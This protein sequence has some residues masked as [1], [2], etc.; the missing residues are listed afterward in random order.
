MAT[1]PNPAQKAQP[2]LCRHE[3]RAGRWGRFRLSCACA[4]NGGAGATTAEPSPPSY[5]HPPEVTLRSIWSEGAVLTDSP[6]SGAETV[7]TVPQSSL[8]HR[9]WRRIQRDSWNRP[10]RLGRGPYRL[11][12]YKNRTV[13]DAAP[14]RCRAALSIVG[15]S[16][17][18]T[19]LLALRRVPPSTTSVKAYRLRPTSPPSD[20][21]WQHRLRRQHR[22]CGQS[23]RFTPGKPIGCAT[24]KDP[25][26]HGGVT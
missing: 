18:A 16:A 20:Q 21:T 15:R 24:K 10:R 7:G 5:P 17:A 13:L 11:G 9:R 25:M 23:R 2:A 22:N 6:V 12:R 1:N 19:L 26:P 8:D 4:A 3:T 14:A